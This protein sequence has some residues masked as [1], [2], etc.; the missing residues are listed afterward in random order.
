MLISFAHNLKPALGYIVM[1]SCSQNDDSNNHNNAKFISS[2][3]SSKMNSS[4]TD[5]ESS[6][7]LPEAPLTC[8]ETAEFMNTHDAFNGKNMVIGM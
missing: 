5:K 8:L 4:N 3:N 7:R 1:R 6:N 2:H